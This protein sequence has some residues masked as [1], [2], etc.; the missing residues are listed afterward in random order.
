MH[1]TTTPKPLTSH[2]TIDQ[3]LQANT[4]LT[5]PVNGSDQS[6]AQYLIET[7]GEELPQVI[8]DVLVY[9]YDYYA[10]ID[11][12]S[13]HMVTKLDLFAFHQD[14]GIRLVT[15]Q[16][17]YSAYP[18]RSIRRVINSGD[19][20]IAKLFVGFIG[21][22]WLIPDDADRELIEFA[23]ENGGFY[24]F[25]HHPDPEIAALAQG[26]YE[27]E[28][29]ST[30][31]TPEIM[32]AFATHYRL[33]NETRQWVEMAEEGTLTE[34]LFRQMI[35]QARQLDELRFQTVAKLIP[36]Q[37]KAMGLSHDE[38]YDDEDYD[39][40][41]DYDDYDDEDY[42]DEAYED[43][44]S[45]EDYDED[46]SDVDRGYTVR[47]VTEEELESDLTIFAGLLGAEDPLFIGS[48]EIDQFVT[49][50]QAWFQS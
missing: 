35:Q 4:L 23:I 46:E 44:E 17:L 50:H 2:D 21:N 25:R 19:S 28:M 5:S 16:K 36:L 41:E 15:A 7:L 34:E 3:Y 42:D 10:L 31:A 33:F 18:I 11:Q 8:A 12:F 26:I 39:Y 38:D 48:F 9:Y 43:D 20:E 45:D 49:N 40:D 6:F 47:R 24:R 22:H 37:L 30:N 14:R 27:D 32:E 1:L 29:E 13:D